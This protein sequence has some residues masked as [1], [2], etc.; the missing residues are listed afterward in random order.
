MEQLSNQSAV[1]SDEVTDESGSLL[2][3]RLSLEDDSL[4]ALPQCLAVPQS[5]I[6]SYKQRLD[7]F[8]RMFK[9]LPE[10]EMLIL[11]YPCA[12]QRDILLQGRMYLSE[13]WIS[14]YSN[15]FRGTKIILP[16]KDI[17]SMSREKMARLIPN[18]IQ[19][20]T[21]TEKYFFA[22]FSAREKSYQSV[23][24]MWQNTL[25]DKTLTSQ[26][27]WQM[28]KQHY[29]NDLGLTNEEMEILQVSPEFSGQTSLQQKAGGGADDGLSRP[30]RPNSL[31]LPVAENAPLQSS[32]PQGEDFPSPIGSQR[33]PNTDESRSTPSQQR[34]P[35]GLSLDRQ[36][37][38]RLSKR[39]MQSLD[40]NANE[41]ESEQSSSETFEDVED[42]IARSGETG[43]LYLNKVF[44]I[45]A[46]KMFEML[47]TDSSFTRKFMGIRRITNPSFTPWQKD[48]SGNDRRNLNY[49]ITI[50]NP[51]IGK[52]STATEKQTLYKESREGQYY[53][54][55]AEVN[56]HDVPYHDY[57]YT[58]NRY[59]IISISKRKCRLRVYCDVKYRKPPWGL[60]KSFI[61]KNS[62]S[63]I[64]DYFRQLET[65]LME[66]EAEMNQSAAESGKLGG[67]RRRR[68]TFSRTI[69]DHRRPSKQYG[70][71]PEPRDG[72][73]DP[74]DPTVP[75]R[76]STAAIVASMSLILL[77]LIVLNLGLFFKLWAM[78]DVAH[79][80]YLTTKHRLRERMETSFGPQFGPK[81]GPGFR[82]NED[83][84]LLKTVLQDS[85]HLLEQLRTSLVVL[86]QNFAMANRTA[87]QQ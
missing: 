24:R 29:G 9:E 49:T 66:E 78:E 35:L 57:F 80:M 76:W 12:L 19:I 11:D 64:E 33:T 55:D 22:S 28:V 30:E 71:D 2:E 85:I 17:T 47:F 25:L 51:L 10:T 83:M 79:R 86:Q 23:F 59:Y 74:A 69:L 4:E 16:L 81:P 45:S 67:L 7:E 32:T 27:L 13:N 34:S 53:L 87:T 8:K 73:L 62:W 77:I 15:V 1:G 84:Q 36:V 37:P 6:P 70:Q 63:G 56:T 21:N 41:N 50:D 72:N 18:A 46:N 60:V 40:L 44:H 43:R 39:S 65:E 61:S 58:H 42:R 26:E 38:E 48:D 68:R 14:F 3:E 5:P 82:T 20:C 54:V 75:H 52:F 31:R